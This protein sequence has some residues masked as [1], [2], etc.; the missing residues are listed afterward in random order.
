MNIFDRAIAIKLRNIGNIA[1]LNS[2]TSKDL[3]LNDVVAINFVIGQEIYFYIVKAENTKLKD[4]VLSSI[5]LQDAMNEN[6]K[7]ISINLDVLKPN[8]FKVE[9]KTIYN[10]MRQVG[11]L[12]VNKVSIAS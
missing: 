6:T 1:I 2:F 5:D 12:N 4:S 11:E 8:Q 9:K 3:F 7:A 10:F